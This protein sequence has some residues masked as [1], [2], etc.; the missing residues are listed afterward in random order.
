PGQTTTWV[1]ASS[2]VS[3]PRGISIVP[4]NVSGL[5]AANVVWSSSN[6]TLLSTLGGPFNPAQ[7]V[8][9]PF[10]GGTA[11]FIEFRADGTVVQVGTQPFAR[12]LVATAA[13][14]PANLPQFNNAAA[15]RGLVIRPSGAVTFVNDATSF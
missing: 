6:P 1:S 7:P 8:G 4:P 14:S 9:T 10:A 11:F 12:L 15:V 3:L 2:A 5:L 13:I